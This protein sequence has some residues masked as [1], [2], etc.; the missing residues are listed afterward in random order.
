MSA[1]LQRLENLNCDEGQGF[2][3]L[4]FGCALAIEAG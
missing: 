3:D 2:D 4:V 1:T